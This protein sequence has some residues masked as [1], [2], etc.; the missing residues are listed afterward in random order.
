MEV[1]DQKAVTELAARTAKV[2]TF[3]TSGKIASIVIQAVM[4]IAVARLLGPTNYGLYTLIISISAFMSSFGNV[5]IGTYFNERIPYLLAK[6]R[7]REIGRELGDG[8]IALLIPGLALFL[9][10]ALLSGVISLYVLHSDVYA[11]LL[12]LSM[13]SILFTFLYAAFNLVLISFNDGK[14]SA[15]AITVYSILQAAISIFLIYMGFGILGAIVGYLLALLI[16]SL[17]Q[18]FQANATYPISFEWKGMLKRIREM[19]NFSMPITYSNIITTLLS[20][21]SIVLLGVIVLPQFIGE[22]GVASRIGT[23]LDVVVG[24]IAVVLIPMFAEAIHNRKLGPKVGKFL[25]YSIYFGLLFTTP[26]IAYITV[27]AKALITTL[28]TP[29]YSNAILYVQLI[30]IGMLLSIFGSY[31]SQLAISSRKTSKVFRYTLVV[32]II[33][34]VSLLILTPLL[35]VIGVIIALFYIGSIASNVLFMRYLKEIGISIKFGAIA[36]VIISNVLLAILLTPLLF[37]NVNP[38]VILVLGVLLI[39]LLYPPIIALLKAIT[40]DELRLL[41]ELS[42]NIPILGKVLSGLLSYSLLFT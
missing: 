27:F 19:L 32:G 18:I 1:Q 26:M 16:S 11:N 20:N 21:F 22:Y 41:K 23:L 28:F 4:F 7:G 24:S 8:V 12:I 10:G 34:V 36:K 14:D 39:L 9:A 6:K 25:Y 38:E 29:S 31:A 3:I 13:A 17:F 40:K 37:L 30:S 42:A 33:E 2:A 5:S 35:H 15:I